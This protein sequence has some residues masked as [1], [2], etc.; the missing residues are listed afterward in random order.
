MNR[1]SEIKIENEEA[2]T[3]PVNKEKRGIHKVEWVNASLM[4][5]ADITISKLS[6][7]LFV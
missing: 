6:P 3:N 7:A 5:K 2:G 4:L 1:S